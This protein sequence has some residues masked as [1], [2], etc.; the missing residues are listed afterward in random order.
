MEWFIAIAIFVGL[1]WWSARRSSA[2]HFHG[3]PREPEQSGYIFQ[4]SA[5]VREIDPNAYRIDGTAYPQF[6]ITYADEDGVV[7][8]RDIFV[9]RFYKKGGVTH[10][11]CW[12]FLRDD[13]RTFRGDRILE[14][15]NLQT[16]RRIKDIEAYWMRG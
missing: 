14:T 2:N 8:K 1:F 3:R 6:N 4:T 13:L 11:R 9:D 16:G 12:C 5:T 10:Y 7:S 15:V